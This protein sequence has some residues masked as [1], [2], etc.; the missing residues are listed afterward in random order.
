MKVFYMTQGEIL[1][2][3]SFHNGFSNGV[4][5]VDFTGSGQGK[6]VFF[7]IF[8]IGNDGADFEFSFCN[9]ACFI[10]DSYFDFGNHFHH[11]AALKENTIFG[12][13]SYACKES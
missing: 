9:G 1:F 4:G 10:H 3:G 12:S 7:L 6:N 8:P 11:C 2:M 13:S 5:R